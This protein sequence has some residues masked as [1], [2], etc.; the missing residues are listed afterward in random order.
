ML[1]S[2]EALQRQ[3][4]QVELEKLR[5]QYELAKELGTRDGFFRQYFNNLSTCATGLEAYNKISEQYFDIYGEYRYNDY[6]SFRSQKSKYYKKA[7]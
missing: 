6:S 5:T 3:A 7:K 4:L 2:Q 1:Q